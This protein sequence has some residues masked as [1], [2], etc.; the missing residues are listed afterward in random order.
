MYT[1]AHAQTL[2][3]TICWLQP[4]MERQ[5]KQCDNKMSL[6]VEHATETDR[7][8]IDI[9]LFVAHTNIRLRSLIGTNNNL[10]SIIN[11]FQEFIAIINNYHKLAEN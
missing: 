11:S 7:Y 5:M 3:H 6:K 1:T 4:K 2:T 8:G 10:I 9:E